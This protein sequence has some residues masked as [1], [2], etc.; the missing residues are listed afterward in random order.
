LV[1]GAGGDQ[2]FGTNENFDYLADTLSELRFITFLKAFYSTMHIT[3][4][5]APSIFRNHVIRARKRTSVDNVE[6][7]N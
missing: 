5:K 6:V 2:V 4:Q 1:S 3:H 7:P